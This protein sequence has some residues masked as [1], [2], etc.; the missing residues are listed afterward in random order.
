[1]R[2][3]RESK[4]LPLLMILAAGMCLLFPEPGRAAGARVSA[5]FS[6]SQEGPFSRTRPQ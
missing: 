2:P 1:M 4:A 3:L 5:Q 6:L